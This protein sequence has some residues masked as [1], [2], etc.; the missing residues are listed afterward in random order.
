MTDV[1]DMLIPRSTKD[2]YVSNMKMTVT[3]ADENGMRV[4]H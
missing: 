2:T 1:S 3:I 4:S